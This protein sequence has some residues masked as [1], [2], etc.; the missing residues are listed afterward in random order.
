MVIIADAWG[1][2]SDARPH[3]HGS[4]GRALVG[5]VGESVLGKWRSEALATAIREIKAIPALS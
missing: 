1:A 5:G 2:S 3:P 4:R